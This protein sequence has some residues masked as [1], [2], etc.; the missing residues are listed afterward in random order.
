MKKIKPIDLDETRKKKAWK[1]Y[2]HFMD[3]IS[4]AEMQIIGA[5]KPFDFDLDPERLMAEFNRLLG[6][7]AAK[8]KVIPFPF[9]RV[10][11]SAKSARNA[12]SN[13][14]LELQRGI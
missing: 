10:R 7:S 3:N 11:K 8:C 1:R 9:E 13:I 14:I 4:D 2:H 6:E 12:G 5:V